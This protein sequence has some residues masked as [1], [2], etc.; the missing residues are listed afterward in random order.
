MNIRELWLWGAP[1]AALLFTVVCWARIKGGE[2]V[3]A[4]LAESLEQSDGKIEELESRVRELEDEVE[5]LKSEIDDMHGG[6]WEAA[7]C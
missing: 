5:S 3:S 7:D 4:V 2:I 1:I 6:E